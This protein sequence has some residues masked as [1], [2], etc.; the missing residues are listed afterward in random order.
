M[1]FFI[2]YLKNA[3]KEKIMQKNKY[4]QQQQNITSHQPTFLTPLKIASQ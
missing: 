4:N 3:K 2:N 1:Y